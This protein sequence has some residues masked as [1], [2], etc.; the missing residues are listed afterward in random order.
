MQ[1]SYFFANGN[2]LNAVSITR[3]APW[4]YRGVCYMPLAPPED[5]IERYSCGLIDESCYAQEYAE[6]V[7]NT[8]DPFQVVKD[9]GL[10][11]ILLGDAPPGKFCHRRLVANWFEDT[12]GIKVQEY[13]EKPKTP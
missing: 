7:L 2:D 6:R 10:D 13:I 11:A 9:L 1:T 3:K 5:L 12:L 4:W 8:L